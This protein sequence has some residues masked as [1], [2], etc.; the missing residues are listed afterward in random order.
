MKGKIFTYLFFF[1]LLLILFL[2]INSKNVVESYEKRLEKA[3]TKVETYKD[4]I[5]TL[6]EENL[7]LRYFDLEHNEDA[8]SY[9]ERFGYD[10][11]KLIPII[12]DELMST[13]VYEGDDHPIIP[14]VSMTENKIMI[15]KI[16]ILN[17]RWILA[18]FTDGEYWGELFITYEVK[19]A[20]TIDFKLVEYFMYPPQ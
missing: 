14:F 16:K 20:N 18:D 15:N 12:K 5:T 8:L 2:F 11:E 17:H 4:S 9:L 6:S 10:V 1:A 7:E 3:E 19:D 13:N